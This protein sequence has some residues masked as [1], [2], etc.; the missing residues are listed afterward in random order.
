MGKDRDPP[1]E[2]FIRTRTESSASNS[3]EVSLRLWRSLA[4]L[5]GG[6]GHSCRDA[7]LPDDTG[8]G[9][10]DR[11]A[12]LNMM[13]ASMA[14]GGLTGCAVNRQPWGAPLLSHPQL[15]PQHTPGEPLQFATSM[16]LDGLGRGVLV[17]SHDG[18]PVKIE[19]NP[20]HPASLGATDVF[21]QAEVLSLYNPDRS[22]TPMADGSPHSWADVGRL[23]TE[24]SEQFGASNGRG[25]HVL[26][27]PCASPTRD[28]L[29]ARAMQAFPEASWYLHAPLAA[30]QGRVAATSV[31]GRPVD[32]VFDLTQADAILT[33][34]GDVLGRGP[35][36][37]RYAADFA[38]R[39]RSR[40][41]P[42]PK[43]FSVETT[44]SLTAARADR[45]LAVPPREVEA[46]AREI[47]SLA[48]GSGTA[49]NGSPSFVARVAADLVRAGS[50]SL[51]V[52][53][54]EQ[55]EAIQAI[56]H[57]LNVRLGAVGQTVRYIE[58]LLREADYAQ[59]L[60]SL[61]EAMAAGRVEA[62]LILGGN[63]A[64]D[65]PRDVEFAELLDQVPLS[66]HLSYSLDETSR[67]SRWHIP[68]RHSLESWGDLRA[69]DGTAGL[70]QPATVPLVEATTAE[71]L[72][73]RLVGEPGSGA[74]LVQATWREVWGAGQFETRWRGA[75]EAG[76]VADSASPASLV[77]PAADWQPPPQQPAQAKLGLTVVF[78]P[79]PSVWDGRFADN[80]WLQE[81]PK[82]L[83]KQV[84]GNAALMAPATGAA[85]GLQTGDVAA[86]NQG[87]RSLEAPVWLLPGHAPDAVT[88]TLGYGR[89]AAGT[90]GS[91]RGFDAYRVRS[92]QQPWVLE[93]V[94]VTATGRR[95]RLITT[96]H[97]HRMEGRDI[98]RV[99]APGGAA[100]SSELGPSM[101]PDYV[102]DG[103]AWGMVIDLDLCLG[104]NACVVACQAENNVPVVGPT[105]V[106][107]GR[108]MHWLRID[109]YY[110]GTAGEPETYFQ[111]MLCMHCE[112]APC[113]IVCPVN[114]TVHSSDGL[115]QMVYSRCVGTRTCSN[116]CPYKV[117]RFNWFNYHQEPYASP[118]DVMNADVTVRW[119][120][121][122][123]KCTYCVQRI[124]AARIA[125]KM[126]GRPIADADVKTACQQACP[127]Q[128]IVF[129]DINDPESAVHQRRQNPRNYAL[130]GELN[131]KPR[132]T[133]LARIADPPASQADKGRDDDTG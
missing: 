6:E 86:F 94:S 85:L 59:P 32:P 29:I 117:R 107:R 44:P 121:V 114:A 83:T 91:L 69:F 95:E 27:Q 33:F 106:D 12:L 8:R 124:S 18:R 72:L 125:A 31:F 49:V 88:L 101:Y 22:K 130:L 36:H 7:E 13:T 109:R 81:L 67:R 3:D 118:E 4:D 102:Y 47:Y 66:V 133:Y 39:R 131:T 63:P 1:Y 103:N 89:T 38:A 128:A 65:A 71:E 61:A 104:C 16:E 26:L 41:R 21:M 56:A 84:W 127:T 24:L 87:G 48:G 112:K 55:P 79:D 105:E 132:T 98:V 45:R 25:L 116:N 42:L 14:L 28:R 110:A 19:G 75:L 20:L 76:I 40:D 108:E 17:R 113:E 123:E 43:L 30:S 126:E 58:P 99:V 115:N 68:A 62:L 100:A 119:R 9:S 78:A 111:P 82:P 90:V 15:E 34:G 52:A 97:H 23:L 60:V 57:A 70:R 96:Q 46:V 93:N 64:Y 74:D 120:G 2:A 5:Q 92:A 35:G 10:I 37:I 73:A 11:R 80:G 77:S 50:Q 51:V 54:D 122:M 53:G 129:G